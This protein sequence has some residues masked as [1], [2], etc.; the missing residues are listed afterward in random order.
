MRTAIFAA[1]IL[2]AATASAGVAVTA[3]MIYTMNGP[4]IEQ[5]VILIDDGLIS[6]VG[7]ATSI[8]IPNDYD[9]LDAAIVTPGLVDAPSS[10]LSRALPPSQPPLI[11]SAS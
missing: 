11:S 1:L 4:P 6:A 2:F 5:G 10:T 8:N 7:P 9:R 3:E